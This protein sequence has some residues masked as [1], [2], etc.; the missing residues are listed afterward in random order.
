MWFPP[1]V[2]VGPHNNYGS[3]VFH[4]KQIEDGISWIASPY[5]LPF[6]RLFEASDTHYLPAGKSQ[7]ETTSWRTGSTE[8]NAKFIGYLDSEFDDEHS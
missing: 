4:V 1:F 3:F 5:V 7:I 6:H 2:G 8:W